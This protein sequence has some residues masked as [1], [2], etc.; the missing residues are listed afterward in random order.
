MATTDFDVDPVHTFLGF[1]VRYLGI[2][3]VRGRFTRVR[4]VLS[5]DWGDLTRSRAH[6]RIEADSLDTGSAERD[7][8]LRSPD[9]LDVARFPELHFHSGEL[10][11][12]TAEVFDVHGHLELHGVLRAVTL[13]AEYGGMSPD[14]KGIQRV[15]ILARGVLDRRQFGLG[16]NR[17]LEPGGVVVGWEVELD[18]SIQGVRPA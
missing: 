12:R 3:R 7:A 14:L 9:F 18:L 11:R 6:L 5:I 4:G 16:W 8:H 2:S 17:P 1:G 10:R 13:E 15:G